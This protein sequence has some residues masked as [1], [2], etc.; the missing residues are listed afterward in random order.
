MKQTKDFTEKPK[1]NFIFTEIQLILHLHNN[2]E[3]SVQ[4]SETL[5]EYLT[6]HQ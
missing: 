1:T 5:R 2:L 4:S 6:L 3:H